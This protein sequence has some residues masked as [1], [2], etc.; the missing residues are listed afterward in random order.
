[1]AIELAKAYVQIIPTT[2]GVQG[3]IEKALSDET[4]KA[5]EKTGKNFGSKFLKIGAGVITAGA[6]AISGAAASVWKGAMDTMEQ[7]DTIDKTSQ[8]LGLSTQAF[9]E[10]DYVLNLAGTSMSNMSTGMKTLTNKLDDAKNGSSSAQ[11]MFA[12]LGL[13]MDDLNSMSRED[14]FGA[15]I[16]G[17]QNLEDSTDRAAL[18]ND[19]FGKSGQELTPV[20][21]QTNEETDALI[22]KINDLGGVMSEDAVK[23]GAGLK[24]SIT[25]L[26]ATFS[27]MAN[28]IVAEFMPSISQVVDGL[29]LLAS[30]DESGLGMVRDGIKKFLDSLSEMMPEMLEIGLGLIQTFLDV[31]IDNLPLIIEMGVEL[32]IKL[33]A[34]IIKAIPDLV[35]KIPDIIKAIVKALKESLPDIIDAGKNLIEGLWE[36]IKK[37]T[38]WLKDKFKEWVGNVTDFLKGLFGIKSPSRLMRDQIGQWIP[39]GIAVGIETNTDA[40]Q[41][42]MSDL[43]KITTVQP[44]FNTKVGTLATD[45]TTSRLNELIGVLGTNNTNIVVTL[46]GDAKRLFRVMQNESRT[47]KQT[48]GTPAFG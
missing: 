22:Q 19:L 45:T 40:V 31:I 36:G 43:A 44:E 23:S 4:D 17:M 1:M 28:G 25:T 6:S 37:S 2:E 30:G 21:N 48:T 47:Y 38:D 33:A 18:A 35:A 3:N 46:E 42:A 41:D 34:G 26:K 27:G 24:D 9:Q 8:K 13:S 29:A 5:S 20:F 15:V 39:K 7:A 16:R 32:I 10:W 11:E 14:V 12:K